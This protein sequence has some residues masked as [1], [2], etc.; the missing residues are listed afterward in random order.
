MTNDEKMIEAHLDALLKAWHRWSQNQGDALCRGYKE[1]P[2]FRQ[3]RAPNAD[4]SSGWDDEI[5]E[6]VAEAMEFHVYAIPDPWRTALAINARNLATGRSVW[7]S[8]RLPQ[9]DTARAVIVLEARTKLMQRLYDAGL[10]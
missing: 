10:M 4:R 2:T 8:A 3:Y 1:S 9:D 6:S 7:R 5:D